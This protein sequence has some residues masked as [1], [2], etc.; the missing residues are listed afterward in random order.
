MIIVLKFKEKYSPGDGAE[1]EE[2][3]GAGAGV[4]ETMGA[5]LRVISPKS[6][7]EKYSLNDFF[8]SRI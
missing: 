6:A 8:K 5:G 3:I 7:I 4:E 1:V 2:T